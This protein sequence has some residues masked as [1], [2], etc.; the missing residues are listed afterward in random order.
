MD[1]PHYRRRVRQQA[2]G[3]FGSGGGQLSMK[4]IYRHHIPPAPGL[5]WRFL[6]QRAGCPQTGR[7]KHFRASILF[8]ASAASALPWRWNTDRGGECFSQPAAR[9]PGR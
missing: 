7:V 9:H 6:V 1:Q 2:L 8:E 3:D 5:D 4:W